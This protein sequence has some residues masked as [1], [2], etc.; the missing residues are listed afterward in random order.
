MAINNIGQGVPLLTNTLT[1]SSCGPMMRR[2]YFE[3]GSSH[4]A[5]E[6]PNK[7]QFQV[8]VAYSPLEIAEGKEGTEWEADA[9]TTQYADDVD[10]TII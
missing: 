8:R 7:K 2:G 3:C 1:T 10:E 6:C 4:L 5:L 9:T